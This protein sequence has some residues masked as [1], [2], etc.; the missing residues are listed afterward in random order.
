MSQSDLAQALET[1]SKDD[2]SV[3]Y[4]RIV[5]RVIGRIGA[6]GF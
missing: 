2:L 4:F 5:G 6:G 1:I 3:A